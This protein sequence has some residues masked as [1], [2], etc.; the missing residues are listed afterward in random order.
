MLAAGAY[1]LGTNASACYRPHWAGLKGLALD[2]PVV[3]ELRTRK[4]PCLFP[5]T[6]RTLAA[7]LF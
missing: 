1:I 5:A 4:P 3:H 2:D 6:L 7:V